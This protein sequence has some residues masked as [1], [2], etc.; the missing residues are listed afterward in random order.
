MPKR[1]DNLLLDPS[2]GIT[3]TIHPHDHRVA[4]SG[5]ENNLKP[6]LLG[7]TLEQSPCWVPFLKLRYA[8]MHP[9]YPLG[10]PVLPLAAIDYY[11]DAL[12]LFLSS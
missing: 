9:K 4:C 2:D 5:G 8:M 3:A 6:M 10:Y 1:H 11:S 12:R 7:R